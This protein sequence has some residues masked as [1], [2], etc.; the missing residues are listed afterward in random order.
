[1]NTPSRR[2]TRRP[3]SLQSGT[4]LGMLFTLLAAPYAHATSNSWSTTAGGNWN[5]PANWTGGVDVPGNTSS[6]ATASSD[7]AT[8]STSGTKTITPDTGRT[9]GGITFASGAGAHT[10]GS[11]ANTLFLSSGGS[12]QSTGSASFQTINANVRLAGANATY[13]FT[14]NASSSG[15]SLQFGG[16]IQG[17][18]SGATVLTLDG[19]NTSAFNRLNGSISNGSSTSLAIV[20]NGTGQWVLN[21]SNSS[22]GGVTLNAGTLSIRNVNGLGNGALTLNGGSIDAAVAIV[23]AKN[24][25]QNWNGNFTFGGT[26]T[27][28]LGTGDVTMDATRTV[29]TTASTLTVGGAIGDGGSG[30]GLTKAGVG[31]LVLGGASTYTGNTTVSAG[32]LTLAAANR[33]AD[34]SNL[35]LAASTTFDTGGFGETLGTLTVNG[36]TTID[37]GAGDSDLVF[38]DSHSLSWTGTLTLLNFDVGIDSLRFGSS[39]AAL[40]VGQLGSITMDGVTFNAALDSSGFVTFGTIPEPS[41]YA[42]M[43]GG[44]ALAGAAL[45]R[46]R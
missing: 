17:A 8:F 38:G 43:L 27:L 4:A 33:I 7:V 39:I 30:F 35:V 41:S 14:N 29:T 1:M 25:T 15:S 44:L 22:T 45:R 13:S 31:T 3:S 19:S 9:L 28:D 20:K 32:K 5:D 10:I 26:N 42:M 12:I 21:S 46:R 24:N 37:F 18:T 2:Q 16:Q 6:G 23:N 11:S 34:A 36:N 40:S